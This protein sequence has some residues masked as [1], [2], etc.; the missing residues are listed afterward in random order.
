MSRVSSKSSLS[1]SATSGSSAIDLG[2]DSGVNLGEKTQTS[3]STGGIGVTREV[4]NIGG[5]SVTGG[6]SVEVSPVRLD[7]SGNVDYEDPTKSSISVGAGAEV[8]G[9]VLGV[10]GGITI[11]TST[12]AVE[13][14][15][16]GGEVAAFG[17]NVSVGS[18]GSVGLEFTF[19]IPFTPIE[20][21]LGFGSSKN[22][23]PTPTPTPIPPDQKNIAIPISKISPSS[24]GDTCVYFVALVNL[25]SIR[26]MGGYDAKWG[27]FA[28]WGDL[29]YGAGDA[30]VSSVGNCGFRTSKA[31]PNGWG[32]DVEFKEVLPKYSDS[33]G[34]GAE[35]WEPSINAN[36]GTRTSHRWQT[37][38]LIV[39][40]RDLKE[41]WLP[42]WQTMY[43]STILIY[44][45]SLY[46]A[47][48]PATPSPSPSP[49]LLLL[50][51]PPNPPPRKEKMDECCK[52]TLKL[53]RAIHKGLGISKFP[54]KMPSTIIQTIPKKGGQPAEP[55]QVPVDDWVDLFMWN[56]KRDDERWGQWEIQIDVKDADLTK[57]GDQGRSI[58][59]PNLAESVA[60]IEGQ[61]LS[62]LTNVEALVAI[63]T[64]CLVESGM[65]RQEAIKGY[66]ASKAIIK[67]MAFKSTEIDV[68]VP[69]TFTAGAESISAL[70]KESEGHIKGT[71]YVEKETLRD[72]LLDLL[73]AAA[74][75]RAVHWQKIDTKTDTKSQLLGL[76]KGSVDLASSLSKPKS[77][78]ADGD[79]KKFD[80]AQNFEDFIDSAEDGFTNSTGITDIQNP[81]GKTRD[82]RPRIR[83]IGD[84]ISQ[85]G[86]DK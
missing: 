19:Q 3:V 6:V 65:A 7:I 77:T 48:P 86:G 71:D 55:P 34:W 18:D 4:A 25:Q 61:L 70:I 16:I 36:G 28:V 26:V 32:C 79:A 56:F 67:Y 5:M 39:S 11:N 72:I 20:L 47:C 12:G 31:F 24:F 45:V 23:K 41:R 13:E 2:K 75:I 22:K 9:G 53:L 63:Q 59:F 64:K 76:L 40:G 46:G 42:Y 10:S 81:Y 38:T 14:V 54:G 49:S 69:M 74:V 17:A 50:I 57:E 29:Q 44:P 37:G 21:S 60:E 51:P 15:S 33:N 82:R 43:Q 85:A 62:L 80:P 78:N 66:L 35:V 52:E 27:G 8:P 30:G 58:K 73:Q 68:S 1:P 83:Q 84:N